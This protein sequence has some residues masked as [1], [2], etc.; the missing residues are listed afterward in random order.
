LL[1]LQVEESISQ[2]ALDPKTL[3]EDWIDHVRVTRDIGSGWLES[4]RTALLRV[5]SALVPATFNVLLN[6][7]HADTAK[8][9]IDRRYDYPFDPRIKR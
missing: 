6:P 7:L 8:V 9:K 4:M 5:P 1:A 3:P 2:E